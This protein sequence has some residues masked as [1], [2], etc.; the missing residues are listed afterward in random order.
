MP[1]RVCARC[2][3]VLDRVTVQNTEVDRCPSC[4]SVWLDLGELGTLVSA[5]AEEVGELIREGGQS[6][7]PPLHAAIQLDCPAC[8]GSLQTIEFGG[9]RVDR[10][11]SCRGTLFERDGLEKG[12][13]K[14]R[15]EWQRRQKA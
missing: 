14:L 4:G 12:I 5:P 11:D 2:N 1:Q 9:V 13:A 3:T 15:D 6:D 10:C 7:A 8:K